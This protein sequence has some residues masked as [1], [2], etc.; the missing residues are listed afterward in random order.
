MAIYRLLDHDVGFPSP[1]SDE[2]EEDGLLAVGGDLSPQRLLNAYRQG[3]F[4]WFNADDPLLWWSPPQR[5]VV[6]PAG[7]HCSRST[8]KDAKRNAWKVTFNQCF[9][10][11]IHGCRTASADRP[12]TWIDERMVSAYQKLHDLGWCHSVEVWEDDEL[13]GGLY[14]IAMFPFFCG[15]SMFSRRAN[16]S[17]LAFYALSVKLC[18]LQFEWIDCQMPTPHLSSLGVE[19]VD[20]KSWFNTLI[21]AH[22]DTS[23]VAQLS[24]GG[25]I[26]L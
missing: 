1:I 25:K 23:P 9:D 7:V 5:A 17:K 4:P 22:V 19:E 26:E 12:D 11:V 6:R 16:A 20:R 13:I 14:G 8:R 10:R 18:E 24:A 15:E 3:I 21:N 2:V